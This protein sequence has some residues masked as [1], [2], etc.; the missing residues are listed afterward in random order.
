MRIVSGT[1]KSRIIKPPANLPVR[2]TTDIAK[3]SLF[4]VLANRI[5]MET[6]NVLDLFSGTGSISY[7]F[8]SRG[9]LSVTSVDI[10]KRCIDFI[11]KAS[12]EFKFNNIKI[13]RNDVFTFIKICKVKYDII[14]ADPPYEMPK[15]ETLPDLI[16][17]KN[18][19]NEN[20]IFIL[21][22]TERLNFSA[23]PHFME[24][25]NYGKVNF[26]FFKNV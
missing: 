10:E 15:I 7:E 14:F 17:E 19:L 5:D 1:H 4:N 24:K 22:H 9:A 21:E 26:S 2:P 16:F 23:N 18:I 12:T 25:R 6:V 11:H 8:A 20:G 13:L 3:E